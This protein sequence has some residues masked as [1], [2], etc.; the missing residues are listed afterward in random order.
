MEDILNQLATLLTFSCKNR[1]M[2]YS[3]KQI[4]EI[5][6]QEL[7]RAETNWRLQRA[8]FTEIVEGSPSGSHADGVMRIKIAADDHNRALSTMLL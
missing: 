3:R 4:E 8:R 1:N 7:E 2:R 6:A 5:L